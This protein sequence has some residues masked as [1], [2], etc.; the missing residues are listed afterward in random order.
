MRTRISSHTFH[1]NNIEFGELG[2]ERQGQRAF[3]QYH[4]SFETKGMI[5]SISSGVFPLRH[6]RSKHDVIYT[7]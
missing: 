3:E 4:F 2:R 7:F 1:S 5:N 6:A